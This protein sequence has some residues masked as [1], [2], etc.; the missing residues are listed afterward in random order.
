MSEIFR[1]TTL[2]NPF[3]PFTQED[4]WENFDRLMG[5]NTTAYLARVVNTSDELTEE[6]QIIAIQKGIDE[7]IKYDLMGNYIKVTKDSFKKIKTIVV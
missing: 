5:Y 6:D 2:D 1:L 3:N 4:E 7:I